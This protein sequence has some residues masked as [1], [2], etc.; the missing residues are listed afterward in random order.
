VTDWS[1]VAPPAT[2][3]AS[4]ITPDGNSHPIQPSGGI[5]KTLI[6]RTGTSKIVWQQSNT[7]TTAVAVR[8]VG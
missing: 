2:V 3:A 5:V 4:I 7:T 6:P 1:A 8:T